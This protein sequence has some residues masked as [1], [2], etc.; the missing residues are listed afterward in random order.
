LK[1]PSA[2]L[3]AGP[4]ASGKSAVALSLA[5]AFDG[6]LI[7]TDSMQ[8]Y[9]DLGILT[10]RPSVE[11]EGRAPHRLFGVIDA[12]VNFSVGL[13]L[14]A[15]ARA[16]EEA[17]GEGKLPVFVGGSGLYFKAL[18]Q[19]LSDIPDVP[20]AVR[21]QVRA[22]AEGRPVAELHAQLAACDP[23]MAARL[24]PTDPQRIL[25]ALEIF[26]ATGESLA[27]FQARKTPPL[28]DI[29]HTMAV[30]LAPDRKMLNERIDQRF[31]AMLAAGALAEVELLKQRGLDPALPIM[32]AHGMPHLLHALRHEMPLEEAIQA[33]KRDTRHYAKR[34][35][36]FARHQL[37]EF[38]WVA[39][40]EA[41]GFV[42]SI[43]LNARTPD[44]EIR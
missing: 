31:D 27:H 30:F 33:S 25:R 5:Q 22:K 35:F 4:T 20:E 15:A 8:V 13:W 43:L 12:A 37:P 42:E 41:H 32:R 18:T 10:A 21:Q 29:S 28:L 16:L 26:A 7:N 44:S 2:I 38:Q 36:T 40:E 6:I 19:G 3:I 39:P 9:R 24:R 11:E 14:T 1:A 17:R 23:L 34:Q